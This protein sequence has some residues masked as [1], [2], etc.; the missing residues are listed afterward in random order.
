L[1][2]LTDAQNL[3]IMFKCKSLVATDNTTGTAMSAQ[4][5]SAAATSPALTKAEVF[6]LSSNPGAKKKILL[7]FDGHQVSGTWW[8]TKSTPVID[9]KA[10]DR[11]NNPESF[12][13]EELQDIKY[14]W[15]AVSEG[16]CV[17]AQA[18][19]HHPQACSISRMQQQCLRSGLIR[20]AAGQLHMSSTGGTRVLRQCVS[21]L[22]LG[23]VRVQPAAPAPGIACVY[24]F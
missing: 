2:Q 7:D 1:L 6:S 10:Y 14:I 22:A 12:N 9:A 18:T 15:R 11:D 24:C 19:G 21:A 23:H 5:V 20:H 13:Q 8:N 4:D 17:H 3:R 16:M